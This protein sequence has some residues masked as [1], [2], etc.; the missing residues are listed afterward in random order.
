MN[1]YD[2]NA[3]KALL[4]EA[5]WGSGFDVTTRVTTGGHPLAVEIGEAIAKDLGVIGINVN[6]QT[7]TF[8]PASSK[9]RC[10][11][12]YGDETTYLRARACAA[13]CWSNPRQRLLRSVA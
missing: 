12:S 10:L 4:A 2:P 6:I 1:K 7:L 11:E 9:Y 5:G 13:A 3:A 8:V